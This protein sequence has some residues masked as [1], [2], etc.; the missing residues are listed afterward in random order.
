MRLFEGSEAM[1]VMVV[2]GGRII[3]L[4]TGSLPTT[5]S[6]LL[7][8][9]REHYLP[10]RSQ[11]YSAN[12]DPKDFSVRTK[13]F[14]WDMRRWQHRADFTNGLTKYEQW[15]LLFS[16]EMSKENKFCVLFN[17]T[18]P[19]ECIENSGQHGDVRFKQFPRTKNS[20]KKSNTDQPAS[21][22]KPVT[23]L[24]ISSSPWGASAS[25]QAT[26]YNV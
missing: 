12:S 26:G 13:L 19:I 8:I 18:L 9:S 7:L 6:W 17:F 4:G 20:L 5:V 3:T 21:Q 10:I 25:V 1:A 24:D 23:V 2:V 15:T 22:L 11:P 14:L 16:K